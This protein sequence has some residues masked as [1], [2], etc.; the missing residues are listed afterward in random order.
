MAS[1]RPFCIRLCTA[2]SASVF[3][4]SIPAAADA[5]VSLITQTYAAPVAAGGTATTALNST[6]VTVTRASAR[7]SIPQTGSTLALPF[8]GASGT[9]S[10]VQLIAEQIDLAYG[11]VIDSVG[12]RLDAAGGAVT[13]GNF[14]VKLVH[15]LHAHNGSGMMTTTFATNYDSNTPVTVFGPAAVTVPAHAA[16]EVF[17]LDVANTFAYN[18]T[19]N[20]IVE[21]TWSNGAVTSDVPATAHTYPGTQRWAL[22]ATSTG[23]LT[24]NVS[25]TAPYAYFRIASDNVVA[26]PFHGTNKSVSAPP[27]STYLYSALTTGSGASE[28][29]MATGSLGGAVAA[30]TVTRT[31]YHQRAANVTLSGTSA[32]NT[33][34]TTAHTKFGASAAASGFSGAF[35]DWADQ[36]STLTFSATTTPLGFTTADPRSFAVSGTIATTIHYVDTTAP[37]VTVTSPDGGELWF[38]GSLHNV[39]W[40]ASDLVGVSTVNLKL[41]TDGGATYPTAIATGISNSGSYSWIV[42]NSPSTTCRVRAEASDAANN[43]GT[44]ASNSLFEIRSSLT[45]VSLSELES[46]SAPG[47]V[48]LRWALAEPEQAQN[49]RVERSAAPGSEFRVIAAGLAPAA[50]MQFRD[51]GVA[52]GAG[53]EYRVIVTLR[54]GGELARALRIDTPLAG[55]FG[56][57]AIAPNPVSAGSSI[58]YALHRSGPVTL[59]LYS[60]DGRR[61]ASRYLGAMSAGEHEASWSWLAG[62]GNPSTSGVFF[63]RLDA[64]GR[65]STR[66]VLVVR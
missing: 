11:G 38:T 43:V 25:S 10:R 64:G 31:F 63:L 19:N 4:G 29:W 1:V 9:A 42:P 37:S 46:E 30:G 7:D 45:P 20:L 39:T 61:I 56:I 35:S 52:A 59:T 55:G 27:G 54:S 60:A 49:V 3:L 14:T 22:S 13:F 21:I 41:S 65:A 62:S 40:T 28:R 58:R 44:D 50:Q 12:W 5:A 18:N 47:Y 51:D 48:E 23:A 2:L 24:G 15:T 6:T 57:L 16:G 36:G 66:R 53:Y 17:M 8:A 33:V 34:G 32:G 26:S